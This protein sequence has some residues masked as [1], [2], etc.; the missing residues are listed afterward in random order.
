VRYSQPTFDEELPI[1]RIKTPIAAVL[2]LGLLATACGNDGTPSATG[3]SSGPSAGPTSSLQSLAPGTL[4]TSSAGAA[5]GT[6]R[7][8]TASIHLDGDLTGDVSLLLLASPSLYSPPPGSLAVVWTDGLQT[9]GITGNSFLGTFDTSLTLSLSLLV[10]NGAEQVVL[11]S[12]A[13]ECS[14]TMD[15]AIERSFA[16]SFICRR[17]DGS[18]AAGLALTVSATGTF[19]ASG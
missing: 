13:G 15:T 1:L 4:P 6:L 2:A 18:T 17:L 11:E 3:S 16:G 14:I 12:S 7:G 5:T 9:L 19:S 8:G 10:R